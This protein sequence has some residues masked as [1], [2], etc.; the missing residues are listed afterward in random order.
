MPI[1][2]QSISICVDISSLFTCNV[3]VITKC[4]ASIDPSNTSTLL[5]DKHEI[6][7]H[8]EAS[9]TRLVL[10]TEEP[11]WCDWLDHFPIPPNL[12][13]FLLVWLMPRPPWMS[14]PS[15][16]FCILSCCG[17]THYSINTSHLQ[18][19]LASPPSDPSSASTKTHGRWSGEP[20]NW[21]SWSSCWILRK[22]I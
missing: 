6:P 21:P 3:Q 8:F 16:L 20:G 22:G 15:S 7:K 9:E 18:A 13:I 10:S 19:Y 17:Y 12:F 1:A 5:T 11:S 2:Q 14:E 4:F